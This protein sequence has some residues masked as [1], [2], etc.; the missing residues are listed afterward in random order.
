LGKQRDKKMH[1]LIDDLIAHATYVSEPNDPD[2][3]HESF[4]KKKFAELIIREC[5]E[6]V[7]GV[8][9]DTMGYHTADR[10]IKEHF[11]VE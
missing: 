7:R 2:Y 3:R 9:T 6:L 1:K 10:K 5:A 4:D 11:G 8:A